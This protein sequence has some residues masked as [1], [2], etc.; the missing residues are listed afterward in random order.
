MFDQPLI[1]GI[2]HCFKI[3]LLH[4]LAGV[5][6]LAV[7]IFHQLAVGGSALKQEAGQIVQMQLNRIGSRIAQISFGDAGADR[8][9]QF[10]DVA[11]IGMIDQRLVGQF[12][13]HDLPGDLP[14]FLSHD[15]MHQLAL[16]LQGA[17]DERRHL[18][19][20]RNPPQQCFQQHL[21]RV[22]RRCEDQPHLCGIPRFVIADHVIDPFVHK[23]KDLL[24]TFRFQGMNLIEKQHAPVGQRQ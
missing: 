21:L 22:L 8:I 3:L 6:H 17:V 2:K 12:T 1:E 15:L 24:L 4:H 7:V 20:N 5:D 11:G 19:E 23:Q 18:N 14:A 10:S 13:E 9:D 16:F